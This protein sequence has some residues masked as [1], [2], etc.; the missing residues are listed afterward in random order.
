MPTLGERQGPRARAGSGAPSP[1][2]RRLGWAGQSGCGEGGGRESCARGAGACASLGRRRRAPRR[3]LHAPGGRLAQ[4]APRPH[5][6]LR[7]SRRER[8]SGAVFLVSRTEVGSSG[9]GGRGRGCPVPTAFAS[10][11]PPRSGCSCVQVRLGLPL[12]LPWGPPWALRPLPRWAPWGEGSRA[13]PPAAQVQ[14]CRSRC[15]PRG[16][17]VGSGS[18]ERSCSPPQQQEQRLLLAAGWLCTPEGAAT[19]TASRTHAS[20]RR[21]AHARRLP[22]ALTLAAGRSRGASA[23][24]A[25]LPARWLALAR[26][27]GL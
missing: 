25:S 24:L 8:G 2:E 20:P 7:R 22:P 27:V 11:P 10:W 13:V 26:N 14:S 17:G 9:P 6:L 18:R 5:L 3:G 21:G 1:P 23:R 19:A 12:P 4:H 15:F 16:P